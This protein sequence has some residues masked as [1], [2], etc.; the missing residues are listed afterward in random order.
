MLENTYLIGK[1]PKIIIMAGVHGNEKANVETLHRIMHNQKLKAC[2]TGILFIIGNPQALE[3]S[4][5]F[6]ETDMNREFGTFSTSLEGKRAQEIA[7]YFDSCDV[8]ID[9]H[10]TQTPC[11]EPFTVSPFHK[12]SIDFFSKMQI[13]IVNCVR[14]HLPSE[15]TVSSDEYFLLKNPHGVALTFELGS[16]FDDKE[17]IIGLGTTIIN[18]TISVYENK[19]KKTEQRNIIFW[20]EVASIQNEPM[21]RLVAGISNFMDIKKGDVLGYNGENPLYCELSGKALFPKYAKTTD[22]SILRILIREDF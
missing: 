2:S 16:I 15:K 17:T 20:K 10:L 9:L 14:T 13:P 21:A 19:N 6:I 4:V 1:N 12:E 8:L 3:K 7:S 11:L 5:R 18:E 22:K